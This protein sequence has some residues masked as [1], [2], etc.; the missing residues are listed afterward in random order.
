MDTG[1]LVAG[2]Y[3]RNEAHQCLQAWQLGVFHLAVSDVVFEEY[4]RVTWRVRETERLPG[5]PGPIL[6]L[7]RD[8]ALWVVP[9]PLS[10]RVCRDSKDDKFIEAALAAKAPLLLARD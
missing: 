3:W 2:I 8:R 5:D 6:R 9:Q 7:I 10:R 1:V 4:E